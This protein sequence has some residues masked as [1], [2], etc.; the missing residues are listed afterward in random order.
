[1]RFMRS[2]F[3]AL[4]Q[5]RFL[6]LLTLFKKLSRVYTF[7]DTD[8]SALQSHLNC[9]FYVNPHMKEYTVHYIVF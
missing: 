5:S 4:I 3:H 7:V 6:P 8:F 1:M 9:T 2:S